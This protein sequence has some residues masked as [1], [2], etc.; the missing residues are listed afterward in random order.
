[1][2]FGRCARAGHPWMPVGERI[3]HPQWVGNRLLHPS[4]GGHLLPLK[5]GSFGAAHKVAVARCWLG[6]EM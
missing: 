1:M 5:N 2:H 4:V 3:H 6:I